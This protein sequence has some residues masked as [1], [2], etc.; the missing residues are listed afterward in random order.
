VKN[1]PSV[2]SD[3]DLIPL[4][5]LYGDIEEYVL[6]WSFSDLMTN[7][8][9]ALCLTNV[10]KFL[11]AFFLKVSNSWSC[12]CRTIHRY[13]LDKI[14]IDPLC[15]LCKTKTKQNVILFQFTS[16]FLRSWIWNSSRHSRQ[17]WRSTK[18]YSSQIT[19]YV[20]SSCSNLLLLCFFFEFCQRISSI[21]RR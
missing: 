9:F 16:C 21:L 13:L 8:S 17:T 3:K 7:N 2:A 5:A 20:F 10:P 6:W 15:T 18:N 14:C 19:K 1:V 11:T 4:F 12:W